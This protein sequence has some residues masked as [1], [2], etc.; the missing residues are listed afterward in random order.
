MLRANR[1]FSMFLIMLVMCLFIS[2][3]AA[4]KCS[5]NTKGVREVP[6]DFATVSLRSVTIRMLKGVVTDGNGAPITDVTLV[7]FKLKS[8][9]QGG[10]DFVGSTNT[11]EKGTYCFGSLPRGRYVLH[12][13]TKGFQKTKIEFKMVSNSDAAGKGRLDVRLELGL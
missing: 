10:G 3:A 7:L 9:E 11:D 13:G 12:V 5:Y 6:F 8:G 1:Y 4:Q 2:S